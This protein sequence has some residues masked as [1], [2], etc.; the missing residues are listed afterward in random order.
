MP[1]LL[2]DQQYGAIATAPVFW[3]AIVGTLVLAF[4]RG[5][6][7]HRPQRGA[8]G[9]AASPRGLAAML[10]AA[11]VPYL[12]VTASYH[13]WWGGTS[14]P[15]RFLVPVL[16]TAAVPAAVAWRCTRS[17]ADRAVWMALLVMSAV[18]TVAMTQRGGGL[19][20][21]TTRATHGPFQEWATR[22]VDLSM[23]LPSVLRDP[24]LVAI[25]VAG[26]WA[27][28]LIGWWLA[29]RVVG[30]TPARAAAWAAP[31]GVVAA[32]LALSAVWEARAVEPL[33]LD[34]SRRAVIDSA[35]P[36]G[37]GVA[38]QR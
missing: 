8:D 25:E 10:A 4:A 34:A 6:G 15:A 12:L 38:F 17:A 5:A 11:F 26:A 22:A 29:L 21:F 27:L 16:W 9:D 13:M 28:A 24:P 36:G 33:M 18:M 14:A 19:L 2:L 37:L 20:T 31:L 35:W 7:G 3:A 30:T 23:A 32:S 1:G